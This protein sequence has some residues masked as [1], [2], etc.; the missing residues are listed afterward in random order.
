ME[1]ETKGVSTAVS[2]Q[3]A[4]DRYP[5]GLREARTQ[6]QITRVQLVRRCGELV[7]QGHRGYIKVGVGAIKFL[8][9][10]ARW[11]RHGNCCGA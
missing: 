2:L 3:H 4:R 9:A 1:R 8:E 11:P 6:A 10:G 7:A 5:N